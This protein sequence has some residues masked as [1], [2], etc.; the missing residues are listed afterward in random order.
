MI[1]QNIFTDKLLDYILKYPQI[2]GK[3]IVVCKDIFPNPQDVGDMRLYI[4]Q[5]LI[6]ALISYKYCL[7][8]K[9]STQDYLILLDIHEGYKDHTNYVSRVIYEY[10]E[11]A[12]EIKEKE[13]DSFLID[14]DF[15]LTSEELEEL[16]N[17][18]TQT[19]SK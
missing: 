16:I 4:D 13:I 9:L 14:P 17:K 2:P 5:S 11:E 15:S 8:E 6:N 19:Y 10:D 3:M 18:L 12:N 1:S 7:I